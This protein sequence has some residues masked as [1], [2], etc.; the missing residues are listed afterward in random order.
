MVLNVFTNAYS[1][2]RGVALQADGRIVGIGGGTTRINKTTTRTEFLVARY[3]G[4]P[5]STPVTAASL[6][7]RTVTAQSMLIALTPIE[8]AFPRPPAPGK[9]REPLLTVAAM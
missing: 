2:L 9:R 6:S 3:L 1:S 5:P 7:S 8:S 4:D